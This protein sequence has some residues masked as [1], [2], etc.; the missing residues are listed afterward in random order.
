MTINFSYELFS[1]ARIV[2]FSSLSRAQIFVTHTHT[3]TKIIIDETPNHNHTPSSPIPSG[4]LDNLPVCFC[5]EVHISKGQLAAQFVQGFRKLLGSQRYWLQFL[6]NKI[7]LIFSKPIR[8]YVLCVT[9]SLGNNSLK[10][11]K[12]QL[13]PKDVN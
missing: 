2:G 12:L 13:G 5:K 4:A 10:L 6:G 8:R 7:A 3:H 9:K 11:Y 1:C